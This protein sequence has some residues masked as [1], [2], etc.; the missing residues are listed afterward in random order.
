MIS[1]EWNDWYSMH[2]VSENV[3]NDNLWCVG[4]RIRKPVIKMIV[5]K[6]ARS[7][8]L[9]QVLKNIR[10]RF[11]MLSIYK[12]VICPTFDDGGCP[13]FEVDLSLKSACSVKCIFSSAS[14][15]S[16]CA[17]RYLAWVRVA[18]SSASSSCFFIDRMRPWYL[19]HSSCQWWRK[20]VVSEFG[21]NY[22]HK[23]YCIFED[24]FS[25]KKNIRKK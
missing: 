18:I 19:S 10:G 4:L 20:N 2:V 3:K 14:S 8:S 1:V 21:K 13:V 24:I 25:S 16:A 11:N 12:F 23:N 17:F 6:T 15:A 7:Q 22:I 5:F 9:H